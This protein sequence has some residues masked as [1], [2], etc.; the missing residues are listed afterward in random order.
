MIDEHATRQEIAGTEY[1]FF[2]I[3][4]VS[5]LKQVRQF[6]DRPKLELAVSEE[7]RVDLDE[8]LLPEDS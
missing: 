4:H 3:V 8:A 6:P 5:K 1:R 7:D 2:P